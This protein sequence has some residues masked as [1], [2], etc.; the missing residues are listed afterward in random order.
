M[1]RVHH[2]NCG[3]M[4]PFGGR[5]MDGF[6]HGMASHLVCHC[7]VIETNDGLVLVDTGFGTEDVLHPKDR[8]NSVFFRLDRIQM[9]LEK[10]ALRQ[11]EKLGFKS[12]DV[13]HI[14]LTHLDFDHAGGLSDFPNATVHL[15][16]SE[17]E[18]AQNPRTWLERSRYCRAQWGA[19]RHWRKYSAGGDSWFG[20]QSV[21]DLKGLPPEILLVPLI[22][23]TWGHSGVA[24]DTGQGWLL[25]AGDAYFF[26][27]EMAPRYHCTPGLRFYQR[28]M[29]VDRKSR[30]SNQKKLRNCIRNHS[31]EVKVFS[32]H[33]AVELEAYLRAEKNQKRIFR[34][35]L[36]DQGL[37]AH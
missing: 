17:L 36:L 19:E 23:H 31:S 4:C 27:G 34:P 24:I 11:I 18:A 10:T 8:L 28:L 30:L 25:H 37:G 13:R 21:R 6:S 1:L 35:P 32:A 2:L 20:F 14:V 5:Y 9:N 29:E 3:T 7:L 12:Q 33:D 16:A 22:G 26:R 15:L